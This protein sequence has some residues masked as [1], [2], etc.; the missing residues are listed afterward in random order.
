MKPRQRYTLKKIPHETVQKMRRKFFAK[1]GPV[2]QLMID[3]FESAPNISFCV[4]D[5]DGRIMHTN[6]YNVDVSGWQSL[7]DMLGY[8]SEELYPPEQASVYGGRDRQVM[9][10]GIPNIERIYG[11]VADRS[12]SLNCVTVRPVTGIDGKRIGTATIYWR[13]QQKMRSSSWYD[14]IRKAVVYLNDHLSE[15]VSIERLAAIANYSPAQFRRLFTKLMGQSPSA[16]IANIRINN[17]KVLLKTT[18]KR[19]SDIAVEVG[20][21]DHSHFIRTF[22]KLVGSTPAE[23]RK[24]L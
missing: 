7:N 20:F 15:D 18:D 10:S 2:M 16:Y 8:T 22:K 3:L 12:D 24:S 4:K 9:E 6:R 11:F 19:I 13:A 21:F 17:A 14:P 23:Y 5:A 1:A